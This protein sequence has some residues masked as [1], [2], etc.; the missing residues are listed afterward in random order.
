[1]RTRKL[2]RE[3]LL[4]ALRPLIRNRPY[5]Q[6]LANGDYSVCE[7]SG[8][9]QGPWGFDFGDYDYVRSSL[10]GQ[11]YSYAAVGKQF[12]RRRSLGALSLVAS[13]N[14]TVGG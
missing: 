10:S 4:D 8:K 2:Q 7:D 3:G 11:A 9:G 6:A 14:A 5:C 12:L 13:S 1:M